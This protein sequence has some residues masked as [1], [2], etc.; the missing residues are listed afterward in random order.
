MTEQKFNIQNVEQINADLDELKELIDTIDDLF[1]RIISPIEGDAFSKLNTSEINLCVYELCRDKGKV[2]SL[3]DV[4]RE[5][6][7][8]NSSNLGN[9]VNNY[10][11]DK[12][13]STFIY[14]NNKKKNID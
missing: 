6:L 13:N 14:A 8:K 5:M 2:L 3:I 11:E 10:Y 7:V 12:K 9:E 1:C 4:I